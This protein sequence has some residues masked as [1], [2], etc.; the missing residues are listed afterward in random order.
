M[1][2]VKR[3]LS[4]STSKPLVSPG[5]ILVLV[6]VFAHHLSNSANC[7]DAQW[8]QQSLDKYYITKLCQVFYETHTFTAGFAIATPKTKK[9][10]SWRLGCYSSP[11]RSSQLVA[12]TGRGETLGSS[13]GAS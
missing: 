2:H 8:F 5:C 11:C 12:F 10:S 9:E 13:V 1:V 6:L 3:G 7:T 4:L